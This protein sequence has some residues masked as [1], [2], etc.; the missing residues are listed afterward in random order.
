MTY[1]VRFHA[2]FISEW[3]ALDVKLKELAGEVLDHL[4][5]EGPFLGGP[6]STL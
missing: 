1:V 5:E 3:K 6:K 4:E 2:D